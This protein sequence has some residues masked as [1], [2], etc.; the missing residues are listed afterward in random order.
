MLVGI[1]IEI[2]EYLRIDHDLPSYLKLPDG[3]YA[4]QFALPCIS[5]DKTSIYSCWLVVWNMFYFPYLVNVIIPIDELIFFRGVAQPPTRLIIAGWASQPRL[6]PQWPHDPSV[7]A[8]VMPDGGQVPEEARMG[9][10][11]WW[12]WSPEIISKSDD[13]QTG[14]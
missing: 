11:V 12:V 9:V 2:A 3:N 5:D 8:E 4:W 7:T 10:W 14:A 6:T 13:A 1:H